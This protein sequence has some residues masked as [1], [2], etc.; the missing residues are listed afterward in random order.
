METRWHKGEGDVG[1]LELCFGVH[2]VHALARGTEGKGERGGSG[3]SEGETKREHGHI[4]IEATAS[5]KEVVRVLA[6]WG[7]AVLHGGHTPF[8]TN[9]WW[10]T[11]WARWEPNWDSYRPI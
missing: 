9:M 6:W 10:A 11:M 1:D 4:H 2:G 3:E 5:T 7:A 8:S